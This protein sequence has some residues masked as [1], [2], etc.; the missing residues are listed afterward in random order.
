VRANRVPLG[1]IL[2]GTTLVLA[3]SDAAAYGR[4]SPGIVV[5]PNATGSIGSAPA[6]PPLREAPA[7]GLTMPPLGAPAATAPIKGDRTAQTR[8]DSGRIV[9][10]GAGF[11]EIN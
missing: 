7:A 5:V 2:L 8:C 3:A 1:A 11:C 9:G 10:S 6:G 4:R